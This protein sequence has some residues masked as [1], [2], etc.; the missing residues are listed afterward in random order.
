MK[1]ILLVF[2]SLS[3]LMG[4]NKIET[5]EKDQGDFSLF[6]ASP[7]TKTV[8]DGLSTKWKSGD[9]LSVYHAVSG[10]TNYVNDGRFNVTDV[11][12]GEAK[13]NASN[14]ELDANASYDWYVYY[15]Q[16]ASNQIKK[17]VVQTIGA[18]KGS[19]QTQNGNNSMA[20]L[21]G[22]KF[23]LFGK[24]GGVA[25]NESPYVNMKNISSILDF[26]IYN[27]KGTPITLTTI[28]VTS[29]SFINGGF[30][31]D[32]T[33][34]PPSVTPD[35]ST[36]SNVA[37][38]NVKNGTAIG[39]ED[40]GDFFMGVAPFVMSAGETLTIDITASDGSNTLTQQ[41]AYTPTSEVTFAQ[42]KIRTIE[43]VF[44]GE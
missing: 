1:K 7:S 41:V 4:C 2:W 33:T 39:T 27:V 10:T 24:V 22:N 25:A 28:K 14:P 23:P 30:V 34:Y 9:R 40:S 5:V 44:V 26:R 19:K 42:G 3:L 8:N 13:P 38:L 29:S 31:I 15:P 6:L 11:E 20:H 18:L 17:S 35:E 32:C 36:A 16:N 21:A 12:T 37:T 43:L